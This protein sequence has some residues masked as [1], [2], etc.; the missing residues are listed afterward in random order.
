MVNKMAKGSHLEIAKSGALDGGEF[1]A[2]YKRSIKATGGPWR[3]M[4]EGRNHSS[5]SDFIMTD[6][7]DLYLGVGTPIDDWEFVANAR[8]DIPKLL[9]EIQR[10]QSLVETLESGEG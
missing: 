7:E 1:N 9:A 3:F 2:I 8:Q 6:G 10:L 4:L 5:G